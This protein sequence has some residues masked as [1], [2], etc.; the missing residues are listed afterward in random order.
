MKAFLKDSEQ[1]IF[2]ENLKKDLCVLIKKKLKKVRKK[3]NKKNL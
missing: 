1:H 3:M 2:I